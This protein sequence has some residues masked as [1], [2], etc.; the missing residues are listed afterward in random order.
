[1]GRAFRD[2]TE[3]HV[4]CAQPEK[5]NQATG[6]PH[7]LIVVQECTPTQS[8]QTHANIVR[9]ELILCRV[10]IP[11]VCNVQATAQQRSQ[12]ARPPRIAS[13]TSGS[14]VHLNRFSRAARRAHPVQ[15]EQTEFT[16]PLVGVM[17]VSLANMP[18]F[19]ARPFV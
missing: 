3:V 13:A 12:A 4:L 18:Q 7:A 16:Q 14:L 5:R 17:N 1:V 2:R 11:C 10:Q 8:V 9:K 19:P 15:P 6:H